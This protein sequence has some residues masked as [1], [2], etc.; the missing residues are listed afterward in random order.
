MN[1]EIMS[2]TNEKI[3]TNMALQAFVQKARNVTIPLFPETVNFDTGYKFGAGLVSVSTI[4]DARGNNRDIYK[5]E[6]GGYSL[7]TAKLNEIAQQAGI[8]IMDSRL[9]ERK[10]DE[11]GQV[12]FI[13]HQITG[14]LKSVDGSLKRITV[15][16]KYDYYNDAASSKT[17]G[18]IKSRRKH[19]EALAES[20][21]M[22]RLY[23]KLLAKIQSSF[24]LDEL[25]KPFLIPYV[26]EDKE[27]LLKDLP[28]E[29]QIAIKKEYARKRLGLVSDIYNTT[30]PVQRA[31]EEPKVTI[32]QDDED[33]EQ[34]N[35]GDRTKEDNH[36]NAETFREAPQKER[37][38][39]ILNL[40]KIKNYKVPKN[41]NITVTADMIARTSLDR[42]IML[43]EEL[44]NM[45]DEEFSL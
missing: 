22:Y 31:I 34:A 25:K 41:P 30:A 17:E 4:V 2:L 32:L 33:D 44:L 27:D 1:T 28:Q 5:N 42:Q 21:A 16:G 39:R 14:E 35:N 23:N 29:E 43:I 15:T 8:R 3:G 38:E 13:S 18:Q 19:A 7:H 11:K 6:S 45:P 12:T 40:I 36:F 10:T 37:I 20:N 24:T 26:L 9:I